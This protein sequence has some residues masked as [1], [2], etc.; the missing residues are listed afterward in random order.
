M[1]EILRVLPG[2]V[3][4]LKVLIVGV[5]ARDGNDKGNLSRISMT[6]LSIHGFTLILVESPYILPS[7]LKAFGACSLD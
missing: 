4:I 3:G 5:K 6:F 7:L 1:V 2:C